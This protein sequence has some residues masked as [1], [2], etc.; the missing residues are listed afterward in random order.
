MYILRMDGV[1]PA[2]ICGSHPFAYVP[3]L[4]INSKIDGFPRKGQSQRNSFRVDQFAIYLGRH[5]GSLWAFIARVRYDA[6]LGSQRKDEQNL[7]IAIFTRA[8]MIVI[9]KE[10]KKN[11]GTEKLE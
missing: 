3:L 4:S 6:F 2:G 10:F 5:T 8:T 9:Y 11:Y 7:P 1:A